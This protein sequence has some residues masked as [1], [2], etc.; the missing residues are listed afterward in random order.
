MTEHLDIPDFLRRDKENVK[1]V[2]TKP[3]LFNSEMVKALLDGRKTQTRRIMK[4][5]PDHRQ[6]YEWKGKVL[7]D[8]EYRVWCWK[9]HIGVDNWE[10]ITQQIGSACPH[11]QVGDLLYVRETLTAESYASK[12]WS[13]IYY[14]ADNSELESWPDNYSPPH[15]AIT[16]HR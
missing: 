12:G 8:S 9:N 3:I 15:N 13:D 11:G 2:K 1:Q 4:P 7:H 5:Q 10:N 16:T 14:K 6:H